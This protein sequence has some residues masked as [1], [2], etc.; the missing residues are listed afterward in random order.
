VDGL[1]APVAMRAGQSWGDN[2]KLGTS[3]SGRPQALSAQEQYNELQ[4]TTR[5]LLNRASRR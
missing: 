1:K 3:A 2:L 5:A 4:Q